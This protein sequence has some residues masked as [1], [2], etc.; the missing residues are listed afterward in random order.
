VLNGGHQ[1]A[2]SDIAWAPAMGRSYHTIAVA[3]RENVFKV[4]ADLWLVCRVLTTD[5]H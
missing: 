1:N 2:I 4:L 5:R 3:S